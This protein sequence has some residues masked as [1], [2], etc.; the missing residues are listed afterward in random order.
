MLSALAAAGAPALAQN[1][2]S[3]TIGP[4][5]LRDFSLPGQRTTPPATPTPAPAAETPVAPPRTPPSTAPAEARER[6][7][8]T[9]R[10]DSRPARPETRPA[11]AAP[12]PDTVR[13]AAEAPP[14]PT[15]QAPAQAP[16]EPSAEPVPAPAPAT[17]SGQGSGWLWPA[18]GAALLLALAGLLM[19]RRRRR[20]AAERESA[21]DS[22]RNELGGALRAAPGADPAPAPAPAPAPEPAPEPEPEPEVAA[23]PR[24][25]LELDIVPERAAATEN[26]VYV[27]YA[28]TLT[29]KGEADAL[30][31]RIDPRLF[32]AGAEGE[33]L[34]FFQGPIHDESGS[35]HVVIP[36]GRTLKLNGQVAM[37]NAE[38]REIELAGRRIFVPMVAINVA[39]DWAGGGGGRTSRS[40]L[41]GREAEVPTE[42]MGPFRL[43]LG[44]RI[45]R[46][47]GRREARAV[48]V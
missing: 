35:P 21:R 42:K 41:V 7:A 1:E 37:P 18:V 9:A 16:A 32:N 3:N 25:W 22:A 11:A 12:A 6:P 48:M 44:P 43:D 2:T 27:R 30:N 38:L 13:P 24:P 28:L 40:W 29:N 14:A 19:L 23:G 33:M 36:P 17:A 31:I 46:S 45:Y 39:Y 8:A 15:V 34:S 20:L 5:Q 10:P 47:V 4:P 26:E